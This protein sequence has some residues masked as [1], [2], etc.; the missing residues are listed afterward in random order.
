MLCP[1]LSIQNSSHQNDLACEPSP[2]RC[3]HYA[4]L[5]LIHNFVCS[6]LAIYSLWREIPWVPCTNDQW[7][8]D[9][10]QEDSHTWLL[11]VQIQ[12]KFFCSF[13]MAAIILWITVQASQ[14]TIPT[15][16]T[17]LF[18]FLLPKNKWKK[19]LVWQFLMLDM[20]LVLIFWLASSQKSCC[21]SHWEWCVC[22]YK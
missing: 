4:M 12:A 18:F 16:Y 11:S 22:A 19:V 20:I 7:Q 6:G 17:L 3:H 15:L 9:G 8:S 21:A 5:F 2:L 10:F 14:S 1:V 13:G